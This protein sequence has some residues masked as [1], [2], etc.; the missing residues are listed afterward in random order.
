MLTDRQKRM[1][2]AGVFHFD[3]G[4]DNRQNYIDAS[5]LAR[6]GLIAIREIEYDQ[7]SVF[8]CEVTDAGRIASER[9]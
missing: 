6:R 9:E 1:L 3:S 4:G 7:Y 2:E 5:D 8:Q